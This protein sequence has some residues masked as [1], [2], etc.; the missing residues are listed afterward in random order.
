MKAAR[1]VCGILAPILFLAGASQ[2]P[3][4][5]GRDSHGWEVQSLVVA[6]FGALVAACGA[7]LVGAMYV[8]AGIAWGLAKVN[9]GYAL[10]FT[11]AVTLA[12]CVAA[13]P[14]RTTPE[15]R[16]PSYATLA[17][18]LSLLVVAPT[19]FF[20]GSILSFALTHRPE[21]EIG[22][23]G[24]VMAIVGGGPVL[25]YALVARTARARTPALGGGKRIKT[26]F[27]FLGLLAVLTFA[28][29]VVDVARG[30]R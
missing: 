18:L 17:L 13:H 29:F 5:R 16:K 10:Q 30:F 21:L 8:V 12:L 11:L 6:S 7:G 25:R 1:V 14:F 9:E 2:V 3:F 19:I 28:V 4:L 15:T 27:V 22:L 24:M 23:A 26:A 20:L